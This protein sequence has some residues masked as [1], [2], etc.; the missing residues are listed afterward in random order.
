VTR[1]APNGGVFSCGLGGTGGFA[2]SGGFGGAG[3]F[4]GSGGLGGTGGFAGSG[5]FGATGGSGGVGGGVGGS[6]GGGTGPCCRARDSLGCADP[7]IARCVCARDPF[8]CDSGWDAT[9][10]SNVSAYGCGECDVPQPDP[11]ETCVSQAHSD[12]ERCACG[13]CFGDLFACFGDR[14]CPAILQCANRTGCTGVDCYA[15]STCQP[16]IDQY[17]GLSSQSTALAIPLFSCLQMSGCPCGFG[18]P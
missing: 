8:C 4:A 3:G 14:G 2:G 9:C 10:V 1:Y 18:M 5:G 12:C 6:S 15:P 17:G 7:V 11:I 16:V 13:S